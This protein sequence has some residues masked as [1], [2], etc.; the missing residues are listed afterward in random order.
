MAGGRLG[1][2]GGR[3]R[4]AGGGW[5]RL[6]GGWAAPATSTR[7]PG[8]AHVMRLHLRV[9]AA[10]GRASSA[11]GRRLHTRTGGGESV[12]RWLAGG[13]RGAMG[14]RR[15]AMSQACGSAPSGHDTRRRRYHGR[16]CEL[17]IAHRSAGWV[18]WLAGG[19]GRLGAVGGR[20]GGALGHIGP[21][22][23]GRG[24]LGAG[25]HWQPLLIDVADACAHAGFAGWVAVSVGR[26]RYR[27]TERARIDPTALLEL[28][29][30]ARHPLSPRRRR[31][32]AAC[33]RR[34]TSVPAKCWGRDRK[35]LLL[36]GGVTHFPSSV[37]FPLHI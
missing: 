21:Q 11:I 27:D 25:R 37:K 30:I 29:L 19:W 2:V 15:R 20:L 33:W 23:V 8:R 26:E 4:A 10:G 31:R 36:W 24:T 9:R 6:G 7:G 5:G 34:H 28:P 1:A 3:L 35:H 12:G 14:G 32:L 22:R 18:G 17:T 13:W 16:Y